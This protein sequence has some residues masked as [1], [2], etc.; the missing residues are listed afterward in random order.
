MYSM[1]LHLYNL[2][3]F[4]LQLI[5][6]SFTTINWLGILDINILNTTLNYSYK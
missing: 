4:L 1:H 2:N 6:K 3:L 5:K